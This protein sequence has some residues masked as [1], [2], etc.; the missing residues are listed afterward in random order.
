MKF[1]I[2]DKILL[3][4]T[5]EEGIVIAI[6]SPT[7]MEVE[8]NGVQFPVYSDEVDHPYLKW[9]TQKKK[10][11]V[12]Q[13]VEIPVEKPKERVKRLAQG[14]YL[15]FMPVYVLEAME[16]LVS[17]FRIYLLNETASAAHFNYDVVSAGGSNLF[18][19]RSSL[20]AFGN[21]YLHTLSLEEMNGQP[22]FHWQVADSSASL[23]ASD[24]K[25]VLKIKPSKLFEQITLVQQSGEP[26]FS[27][28]LTD[29]ILGLVK[30]KKKVLPEV[31]ITA[32][33]TTPENPSRPEWQ[34]QPVLDLHIEAL[35][36]KWAECTPAE[37]LTIQLDVLHYHLDMAI[38]HQQ[39]QMIVIHGLGT[40][41]L[42]DAV[43]EVL[44]NKNGITSFRNEWMG[45][46]GFGATEVIFDARY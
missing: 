41:A 1:S 43:H 9:F 25:G 34:P 2:G 36:D 44:R 24:T 18:H 45:S 5:D 13:P 46:Y 38:A 21:V 39:E 20:H 29:E 32:A 12:R 11:Q 7:M 19:H 31:I 8:V 26:S 28:L 23:Q 33:A 40:G 35:T 6:I 10:E 30:P 14:I 42:K 3:K 37:I 16:D 22:R 4:R 17:H 15:S 27:Y